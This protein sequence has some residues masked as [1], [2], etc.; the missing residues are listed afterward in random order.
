MISQHTKPWLATFQGRWWKDV[1]RQRKLG[2]KISRTPPP[3]SPGRIQTTS[4]PV[5][6]QIYS[7]EAQAGSLIN[8]FKNLIE[9]VLCWV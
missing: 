2:G 8:S 7:Q 1:E 3:S 4:L 9:L 6:V 5:S